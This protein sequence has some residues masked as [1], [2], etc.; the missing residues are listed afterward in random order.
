VKRAALLIA[1]VLALGVVSAQDYY[2]A[3]V[4]IIGDEDG[5][6]QSY[7]GAAGGSSGVTI[8]D[9]QRAA[10]SGID[11]QLTAFA[12]PILAGDVIIVGHMQHIGNGSGE[13]GAPT[14]TGGNTYT[15]IG[16]RMVDDSNNQGSNMYY[17]VVVTGGAAFRVTKTALSSVYGVVAMAVRGLSATPYNGD[18][19]WKQGNSGT[20]PIRPGP[21]AVPPGQSLFVGVGS[22]N[23]VPVTDPAGWNVAGVSGLTA[24][25]VLRLQPDATNRYASMIV[26]PSAVAED[27][28]WTYSGGNLWAGT[29]ASFR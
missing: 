27:P 11:T 13:P 15:K 9:V 5:S 22:A 28:L 4:A 18:W 6:G 7:L 29:I 19:L 25:M 2:R 8:L 20:G 14:D 16:T 23:Q 1:C 21:T 17:A 3:G 26:K 12:V 24:A 10:T